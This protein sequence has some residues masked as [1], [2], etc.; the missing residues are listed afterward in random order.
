MSAAH[1]SGKVAL[2]TGA[3]GGIGAEI[4]RKFQE[5][6]ASVFVADTNQVE[7]EKT[8]A[9]IGATF[10]L[11]DVTSE[12][13]W[14]AAFA[15][16]LE[17]AG[18][19]D[20]LVNNAGINIRKNIEEMDVASFDAMIAVNVRGPFIGI[21]HALPIMRTGGGGVIL[22]M[23]SICGLVGHKFTN[24]TYTTTKGALTMLTKSVAVRYAKDNIRCNSIHAS[25]VET[26]LV[27]NMLKDPERRAE[28]LGE[29]P[30]G[31]L[32]STAD[33]ANAFVYLASDEAAFI[34]GVALAIDGGLTAY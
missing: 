25:T 17:R 20:I 1:L 2:I 4:A 22:N 18:R 24:E 33:V 32:A 14:K 34:N 12:E 9:S 8:A 31:R 30:L 13:S 27:Q 6:G 28:R 16:V 5:E 26:A 21:K 10:V 19:L 15:T 7:G 29:I 3:A 11:L 23:S